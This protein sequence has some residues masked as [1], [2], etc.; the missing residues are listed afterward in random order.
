MSGVSPQGTERQVSL[1]TGPVRR[2]STARAH[3]RSSLPVGRRVKNVRRSR[4]GTRPT[5]VTSRSDEED[6]AS[7]H[8]TAREHPKVSDRRRRRKRALGDDHIGVVCSPTK[9]RELRHV[10][11]RDHGPVEIEREHQLMA[12]K[13][14][15][16]SSRLRD[17]SSDRAKVGG[18]V[19]AGGGGRL[20]HY[21]SRAPPPPV[22]PNS[23]LPPPAPTS[24]STPVP[25]PTRASPADPYW[26]SALT[27]TA[28]TGSR[29]G[30]PFVQKARLTRR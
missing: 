20:P 8:Q 9:P 28:A 29:P 10:C 19:V 17:R 4:C 3:S 6:A 27:S 16:G 26:A 25:Q 12:I 2:S 1:R 5:T 22:S 15:Q 11:E 18:R 7:V 21:E 24:T 23:H 14:V 13:C 30:G